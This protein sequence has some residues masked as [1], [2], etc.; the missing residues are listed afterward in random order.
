MAAVWLQRSPS[1]ID[2]CQFSQWRDDGPESVRLIRTG[3]FLELEQSQFKA[4][5]P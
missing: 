4:V 2:G 5:K 3:F 1:R